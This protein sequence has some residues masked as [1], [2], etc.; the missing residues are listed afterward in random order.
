MGRVERTPQAV[1][2]VL[3]IWEYVAVKHFSPDAADRLLRRFDEVL[4]LLS[5]QPEMGTRQDPFSAGLRSF[6]I[7]DFVLFYRPLLDGVRL[8]RLLH[9]ARRFEG[10]FD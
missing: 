10:L 5:D 1:D 4:H 9:G 7:G 2:D 8:I 6:S 3:A